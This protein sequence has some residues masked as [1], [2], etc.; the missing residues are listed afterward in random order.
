MHPP[1]VINLAESSSED[2]QDKMDD[3][4]DLEVSTS[5]ASHRLSPL[6]PGSLHVRQ[7]WDVS[8]LFSQLITALQHCLLSQGIPN[9]KWTADD[10]ASCSKNKL[11]PVSFFVYNAF[12]FVSF[13]F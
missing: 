1:V 8:I 10:V 5:Q 12:A 11:T 9:H 3:S 4:R 7:I 2:E 6:G 13:R